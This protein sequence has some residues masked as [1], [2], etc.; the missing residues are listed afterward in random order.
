M[1]HKTRLR[2][3]Q[4]TNRRPGIVYGV[5][6]VGALVALWYYAESFQLIQK[7]RVLF[8]THGS[9]SSSI[10]G[11]RGTIYDRNFKDMAVS[12]ERV[13]VYARTRELGSV[14]ETAQRLATVLAVDADVL[15]TRLKE[16]SLRSWV[17]KNISQEQ[18]ELVRTL[19]L[20]GIFLQRETIRYYPQETTA[21]H[22]IGYAENDIGLA[23]VEYYYDRLTR[24]QLAKKREAPVSASTTR[25]I[26]LTLDLK[27]QEIIEN[28]IK[29]LATD[30]QN[31]RIGAY[32]YNLRTGAILATAQ[33]PN[34]NPNNYRQYDQQL[35]ENLAVLPMPLPR[36]FRSFL[37]DSK[38]LLNSV[39]K[40]KSVLPWSIASGPQNLGA[41]LRL[42]DRFGLTG[43]HYPDFAIEEP[44]GLAARKQFFL[45][46]AS[47]PIQTTVP[48]V[49]SP[50][51]LLTALGSIFN[52]G[53][54]IDP[55]LVSKEI[56]VNTN[57][58]WEVHPAAQ[59]SESNDVLPEAVCEELI[60]EFYALGE[61]GDLDS[62]ILND[63]VFYTLQSPNG[64]EF[65]KNQV[66]F[67]ST[68]GLSP[69]Y[70]ML[71]TLQGGAAK[72][73][74]KNSK[75]AS[76]TV[77]AVNA[78]LQRIAVLQQIGDSTEDIAEPMQFREDNYPKQREKFK[79]DLANSIK[80]QPKIVA[81][82]KTMP[83]LSGL[84]LR[85]SLRLLQGTSCELKVLGTGMVTHQ[86][87]A[88]GKDLTN[89]KQCV[90]TMLRSDEITP[91]IY[92]Q[93]YQKAVR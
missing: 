43:N 91:E 42:W 77:R 5:L 29:D 81:A 92:R 90:L 2:G 45:Q 80:K 9:S 31:L 63:T 11:T 71:L 35:I 53:Q 49:V 65:S 85:K 7:I 4:E 59:R 48:E 23:G 41:E 60:K 62:R 34:I 28:L 56:D 40:G 44:A 79:K 87:P 39:E 27:I 8:A 82:V 22:A 6:L 55:Y 51:Q 66:V 75:A 19:N 67:A 37:D 46:E 13:S 86:E 33:F 83:D 84:S 10:T 74:T 54:R 25:N 68:P 17:V 52:G 18:E 26:L 88:A 16:D 3:R 61:K 1:T 78:V 64:V 15:R 72:S 47:S 32:V 57:Q 36:K 58:A 50:M 69:D 21:G 89:V 93:R 38:S 24:E 70:L 12:M 20:P 73:D 14:D 76:D 30:R